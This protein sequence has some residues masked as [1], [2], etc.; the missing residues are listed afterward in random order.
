MAERKKQ[1]PVAVHTYKQLLWVLNKM[2]DEELA[3]PITIH[4]CGADGYN[5]SVT[6]SFIERCEPNWKKGL[7][8]NR[9]ILTG[10]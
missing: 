6:M 2:S 10:H 7:P 3:M 1:V 4:E 5:E 9:L 8:D